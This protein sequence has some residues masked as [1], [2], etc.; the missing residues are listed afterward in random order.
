[1]KKNVLILMVFLCAS[2]S[3]FA[4][5][6]ITGQVTDDKGETLIGV[7]IIEDQTSNG[8]TTDIDGTFSI[9]VSEGAKELSFSY[10]GYAT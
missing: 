4:Q 1:M 6:T 3:L 8:V 5:R 7:T 2:F 10:T 9:T